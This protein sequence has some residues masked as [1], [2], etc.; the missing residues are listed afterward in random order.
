MIFK[1]PIHYSVLETTLERRSDRIT[2]FFIFITQIP[3]N[4]GIWFFQDLNVLV[5]TDLY[6]TSQMI[7]KIIKVYLQEM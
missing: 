1:F 4:F 3:I 7:M 2:F 5:N 6:T